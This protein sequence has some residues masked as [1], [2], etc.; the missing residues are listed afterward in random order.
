MPISLP[1]IVDRHFHS[2]PH[3]HHSCRWHLLRR[4]VVLR[5]A[6]DLIST[7]F[8]YPRTVCTAKKCTDRIQVNGSVKI[9]YTTHCH[10]RC[11]LNGV[12]QNVINNAALK[13][14]SAMNSNGTCM[15]CDC[16]WETHMH[17]TY[18]TKQ[19]PIEIVDPR[20]ANEIKTREEAA[21]AIQTARENITNRIM[22]LEDEKTNLMR[23]CA[24][25]SKF[26]H[27]NA[28]TPYNDDLIKYVEHMIS[29]AEEKRDA[30]ANN[31]HIIDGLK[32]MI[33]AYQ[34]EMNTY[35]D[36]LQSASKDPTA[37]APRIEDIQKLID[38]LF[39]LQISGPKLKQQIDIIRR[40]LPII[41]SR[42]ETVCKPPPQNKGKLS[43]IR[44]FLNLY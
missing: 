43:R 42:Y 18:E 38:T 16:P 23:I 30:G 9:D 40:G 26:L 5:P 34:E 17:I 13:Q 32:Q 28:I 19:V 14:C 25:L 10:P 44:S 37:N 6:V 3:P 2:S 22:K 33:G 4:S 31:Q 11:Y 7:H 27:K 1:K 41:V 39:K 36:M 12:A 24:K 21:I 35:K 15:K 29:A 8:D 20:I